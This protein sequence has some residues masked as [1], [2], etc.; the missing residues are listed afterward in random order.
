M[1]NV[2][3]Y[4]DGETVDRVTAAL[5]GALAPGGTLLLGAADTLCRDSGRLRALAN[6]VTSTAAPAPARN[7]AALRRPLGRLP[8]LEPSVA[9][10]ERVRGDVLT[11]TS[12]VLASDPLNASAHFLHGL[13]ELEAHNAAAAVGALRR[14]LYAEPGFGLAAFGLGRAYE[15]LG[16]EDRARRSY[17]RA[18]RSLESGNE[19]LDEILG[20][21]DLADVTAAC[22][23]RLAALDP[24]YRRRCR[25]CPSRRRC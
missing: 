9:A 21:V 7:S 24:R 3:I 6:A 19:R 25:A 18:L 11:E 16:N 23:A 14:A 4:F 20:Q 22:E 17:E 8:A 12:R 1:P 15:A 5:D 10:P 13:A 2:L